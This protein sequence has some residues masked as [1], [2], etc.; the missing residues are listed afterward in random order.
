MEGEEWWKETRSRKVFEERSL[1]KNGGSV[2]RGERGVKRDEIEGM[3][4]K[5]EGA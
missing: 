5:G 3:V 1:L 4:M 2:R